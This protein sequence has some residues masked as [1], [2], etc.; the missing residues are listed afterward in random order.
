MTVT[1][2]LLFSLPQETSSKGLPFF[3]PSTHDDSAGLHLLQGLCHFPGLG[4]AVGHVNAADPGAFG[5]AGAEAPPPQ[6]PHLRLKVLAEDVVD[7]R[8]VHG[9]ALGKHARQEADLGRDGAAVLEDGPQAHH[10]VW[11]PAAYEAHGDQHGDLQ[12][13]GEKSRRSQE[14]LLTSR[15]LS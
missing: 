6:L 1:T 15:L 10:A 13:G 5:D 12:R 9:G 4:V 11:R 8:V 3:A 7:E 2:L 14:R